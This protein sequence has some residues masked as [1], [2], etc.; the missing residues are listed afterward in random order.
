LVDCPVGLG[1]PDS[2]H[3]VLSSIVDNGV[4]GSE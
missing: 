3:G 2:L 4:K 1:C